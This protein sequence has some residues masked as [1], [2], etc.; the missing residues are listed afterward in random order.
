MQQQELTICNKNCLSAQFF[1]LGALK[2]QLSQDTRK[3]NE[4]KEFQVPHLRRYL[5]GRSKIGSWLRS[6]ASSHSLLSPC[7]A[8]VSLLST[9]CEDSERQM[10]LGRG[11]NSCLQFLGACGI[12][13]SLFSHPCRYQPLL[14]V[15]RQSPSVQFAAQ[16]R[17]TSVEQKLSYY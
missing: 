4:E 11:G 5:G 3:R 7:M 12:L 15:G 16:N 13:I 6:F 1:H 9:A 8:L 10:G 14:I 17:Q 2:L